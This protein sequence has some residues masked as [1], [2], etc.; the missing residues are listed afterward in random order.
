MEIKEQK[1]ILFLRTPTSRPRK[2]FVDEISSLHHLRDEKIASPISIFT[3][4][5]PCLYWINLTC[6][7]RREVFMQ[8]TNPCPFIWTWTPCSCNVKELVANRSSCFQIHSSLLELP[9]HLSLERQEDLP[10]KIISPHLFIT[11]MSMGLRRTEIQVFIILKEFPSE[12]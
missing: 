9:G 11:S 7:I 10:S 2:G 6:I 3:H 12:I 5:K 8:G 4:F 1:K